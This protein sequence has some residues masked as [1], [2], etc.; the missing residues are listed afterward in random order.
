MTT[1]LFR[2]SFAFVIHWI[3]GEIYGI[4]RDIT[5]NPLETFDKKVTLW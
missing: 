4:Y 5:Q 2:I 1:F 3:N